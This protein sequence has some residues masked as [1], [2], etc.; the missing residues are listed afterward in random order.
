[1]TMPGKVSCGRIKRPRSE[2]NAKDGSKPR[3]EL[4][5]LTPTAIAAP[6]KNSELVEIRKKLQSHGHTEFW[7]KELKGGDQ[8]SMHAV[9]WF[10]DVRVLCKANIYFDGKGV[11]HTILFKDGRKKTVGNKTSRHYGSVEVWRL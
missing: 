10:D 9:E 8:L 3:Q 5:Q 1:M 6:D 2:R 4:L 7:N 11:S